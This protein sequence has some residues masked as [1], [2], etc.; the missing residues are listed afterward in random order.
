MRFILDAS[1]CSMGLCL[2]QCQ[3]HSFDDW[4][5]VV[6]FETVEWGPP[7]LFIFYRLFWQ[8]RSPLNLHVHFI[9]IIIIIIITPGSPDSLPLPWASSFTCL[10]SAVNRASKLIPASSQVS[11]P[12]FTPRPAEGSSQH[13]S[14]TAPLLLCA[15]QWLPINPRVKFKVPSIFSLTV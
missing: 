15:P 1:F 6:R 7:V 9:I 2:S 12:P 5:F 14:E 11:S 13:T 8:S 4:S 10:T 3:S